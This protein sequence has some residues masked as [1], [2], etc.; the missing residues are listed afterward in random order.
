MEPAKLVSQSVKGT[1]TMM[2]NVGFRRISINGHWDFYLDADNLQMRF[3]IAG[4][5]HG[6]SA[7]ANIF[8]DLRSKTLTL[9][10]TI[11]WMTRCHSTQMRGVPDDLMKS[12]V[13]AKLAAFPPTGM[14][15]NDREWVHTKRRGNMNVRVAV[16]LDHDNVLDKLTL[17]FIRPFISLNFNMASTT[18]TLG[19]PDAS[20]FDLFC[21]GY[22]L[23]D[24]LFDDVDD[25]MEDGFLED[26][27]G[28][29]FLATNSSFL[30]AIMNLG[31][32]A[33]GS[34]TDVQPLEVMFG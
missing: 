10:Y 34:F 32:T 7:S 30:T 3:D 21:G 18:R 19:K 26:K 5:V 20:H 4:S 2:G 29:P 24:G 25:E 12:V 28:Y 27:E 11:G 23:E 16:D 31:S 9:K 13:D 15:G 17:T 33:V 8:A 14:N 1:Y 22:E 6:R